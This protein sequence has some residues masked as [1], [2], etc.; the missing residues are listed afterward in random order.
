MYQRKLVRVVVPVMSCKTCTF[1]YTEKSHFQAS[2]YVFTLKT[3]RQ[4]NVR[5]KT[6][7][8]GKVFPQ[9]LFHAAEWAHRNI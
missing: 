4:D 3:E 2:R 5:L 6:R 7:G 9:A 1:I 8:I